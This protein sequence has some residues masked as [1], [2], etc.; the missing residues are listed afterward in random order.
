MA[1]LVQRFLYPFSR[2]RNGM[3]ELQRWW[4]IYVKND[5]KGGLTIDPILYRSNFSEQTPADYGGLND[6]SNTAGVRVEAINDDGTVTGGE[7]Q[8]IISGSG[9]HEPRCIVNHK[10]DATYPTLGENHTEFLMIA[11]T[12]ET[13]SMTTDSPYYDAPTGVG[14][15]SRGVAG[16]IGIFEHAGPY[17]VFMTVQ[18]FAEMIDT[19]RN[20]GGADSEKPAFL[21]HGLESPSTALNPNIADDPRCP[22]RVTQTN[23]EFPASA[24]YRA[25]V[26]MPMMLDNNQLDYRTT[27]C[28]VSFA[29]PYAENVS[30]L[31]T[32]YVEQGITRYDNQPDG[33]DSATIRYKSLGYSGDHKGGMVGAWSPFHSTAP[34]SAEYAG[35]VQGVSSYANPDT[36]LDSSAAIGPKYRMRMALAVFLKDGTYE[37][38][39]G[40][41]IIPYIYDPD[42]TIGGTTTNTMY[43]VWNGKQ[44]Y[45]DSSVRTNDCSAQI[46]PMFDFVQGPLS[47]A[48]QGN[49]FDYSVIEGEHSQWPTLAFQ[50]PT[51]DLQPNP[52]M[53]SVRPNPQRYPI[54]GI[55]RTATSGLITLYIGEDAGPVPFTGGAGMPIY[56]S[57]ITGALGTE[58]TDA[59]TRWQCD[60]DSSAVATTLDLDYNGWW[61]IETISAQTTA[62][63]SSFLANGN[64]DSVTYQ[65]ITFKPAT[66]SG[67]AQAG[68]GAVAAYA[69]SPFTAVVTS[70]N[71]Y[72]RQ[73]RVGGYQT[74]YGSVYGIGAPSG[75]VDIPAASN[76]PATAKTLT[77]VKGTG[78]GFVGGMS[79]PASSAGAG[80]STDSTYPARPVLNSPVQV[81][82]ATNTVLTATG[83][84][85]RGIGPVKISNIGFATAPN[86]AAVGNGSLRIPPPIGW[87]IC[88]SYRG[89]ATAIGSTSVTAAKRDFYDS[90]NAYTEGIMSR[91]AQRG[92]HFPLWSYMDSN[93]GKHAWEY[94]KPEH[95]G[96]AWNFGRNRIWPPHERIGTNAGYSPSLLSDAA[97]GGWS[98]TATGNYSASATSTTKYGL[99]EMGC[100]P[101]W[102]DFEMK[103]VIP[104]RDD[105]MVR[106]EFDSGIEYAVYGRHAM[107][108]EGVGNETLHGAGFYPT[109][110]GAGTMGLSTDDSIWLHGNANSLPTYTTNN[111]AIWFWGATSGSRL[112]GDSNWSNVETWPFTNGQ[113][114]GWGNMGNNYGFGTTTTINEGYHTIRAVFNEGGMTYI[115]DGTTVGTDSSASRT[116]WGMT[117]SVA[118]AMAF[119]QN[120]GSTTNDRGTGTSPT[121]PN[122]DL[123]HTDLQIDEITLRQIPSEAMLPITADTTTVNVS[124]VAKYMSLTVEADN[125]STANGMNITATIMTANS[126]NP[127]Y[128][129]GLANVTGFVEKDLTFAGGLGSLDL[130]GLPTAVVSAGFVIRFNFYIPSASQTEKHPIDW[131]ALPIIRKWTIAYDLSP[132]ATLSCIGNSFDG[133]I[134]TPVGTKVGHIISF[135]ASAVTTDADRTISEVKFDFGDGTQTGW[136]AVANQTLTSTTYDTAHVYSK[137]GT[138][139]AVCYTRDDNANESDASAVISVVVAEAVPVALLKAVPSM[140]RA[141]QVIRFDGS[142][143]Y[144]VSS[145]TSRSLTTYTFDFG[146]GS[147]AVSGG[148]AYSDHT[149]ATAGEF[150]ATLTVTDNAA[151]PNTSNTAKVAVKILP[152]TLVVPLILNSR[153]SGFKRTRT[154]AFT[155]TEVLDAVYPE[156]T[157]SGQRQD[158]FVLEGKFL[159]ATAN[160]DIDFMEELLHSGALIEFEWESVNYVGTPD[161]RTFVGRMLSFD[162]RREG[163]AHGETPYSA[164]FVR[165]AGLGA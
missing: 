126:L 149:F 109:T 12:N 104:V 58:A 94:I 165:E 144:V 158:E 39:D 106:I 31:L 57:G 143:S 42:R 74:N 35:N 20:I 102:L 100:S 78:T 16:G 108:S 153:P 76:V 147:S 3:A 37:I 65:T 140:V 68:S 33:S 154:A 92:I 156:V 150:M 40:G 81:D 17:P 5:G 114:N 125:I 89:S 82:T 116:I 71:A 86:Q 32:G 44:G 122:M 83:F 155:Q 88:Q 120:F 133:D 23:K 1:T 4:P 51:G 36:S 64:S 128:Q 132:T 161:S 49:N 73:G 29:K 72:I 91:W 142:D 34:A 69:I 151:S 90:T 121:R 134:T 38:A 146:D 70:G 131:G 30:A 124:G 107:L 46:F 145:D 98:N 138:F 7:E 9:T 162:Y 56:I 18:E 130:S 47:P 136:I 99:T 159:K 50:D 105:R 26:F 53:N 85:V 101:I 41:A 25:T 13:A 112:F 21:P 164:S 63:T 43:S 119:S 80:G 59:S 127:T 45:G 123:S 117:I 28:A 77:G 61:I 8:I 54:L 15:M 48:A 27:G 79:V 93:T 10:P 115:K 110:T 67:S 19:Y 75:D 11:P 24:P 118:D 163:G 2:M 66:A 141:G 148:A 113:N 129:E 103:A 22:V 96:G 135:R 111:P 157:D 160:K 87:D 62:T 14:A 97:T 60:A 84:T 6:E 139:S 55:G 152:A 95:A 52:R 137:A